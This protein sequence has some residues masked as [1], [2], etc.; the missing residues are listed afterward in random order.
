MVWM[1]KLLCL[2]IRINIGLSWTIAIFT[3]LHFATTGKMFIGNLPYNSIF[4]I[5]TCV[6]DG[7]I[8]L[9][10]FLASISNWDDGR[11]K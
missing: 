3:A 10:H 6:F 1:R 4:V 8:V 11:T 5:M 9:P 2:L 7:A